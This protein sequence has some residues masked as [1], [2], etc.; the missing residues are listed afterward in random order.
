MPCLA[1][2]LS[3][4]TLQETK[5][6]LAT[7]SQRCEVLLSK[8]HS[9]LKS[10]LPPILWPTAVSPATASSQGWLCYFCSLLISFV[11]GLFLSLGFF[12]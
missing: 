3:S 8:G 12:L 9:A 11:E 7:Y 10:T 2:I 4:A 5:Q 1:S 6:N